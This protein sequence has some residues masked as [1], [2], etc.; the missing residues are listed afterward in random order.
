MDN[1]LRHLFQSL[2][3]KGDYEAVLGNI[4]AILN[5]D[6]GQYQEKN[7]TLMAIVN[8]IDRYYSRLSTCNQCDGSGTVSTWSSPYTTER[9]ECI[10]QR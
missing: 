7:G 8:G 9:V 4:L 5:G 3:D 10:C 6:G 1:S 2:C